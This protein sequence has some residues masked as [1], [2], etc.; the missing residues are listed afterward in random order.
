MDKAETVYLTLTPRSNAA[1][2][3][4]DADAGY[5]IGDPTN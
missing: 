5:A 1:A 3:T 2:A 4:P